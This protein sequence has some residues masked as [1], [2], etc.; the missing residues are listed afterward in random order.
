MFV[1]LQLRHSSCWMFDNQHLHPFLS[2]FFVVHPSFQAYFHLFLIYLVDPLKAFLFLC[3]SLV[4]T[5]LFP[6]QQTV[7]LRSSSHQFAHSQV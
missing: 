7:C 4:E 2:D 6:F 1:L 5:F 3:Y